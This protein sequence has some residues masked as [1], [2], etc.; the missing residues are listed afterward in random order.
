[1]KGFFLKEGALDK[2]LGDLNG[3]MLEAVLNQIGDAVCVFDRDFNILFQSPLHIKWF[4][5]LEEF[6][7]TKYEEINKKSTDIL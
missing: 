5:K 4:D 6:F 1:M 2:K 7:E 3:E